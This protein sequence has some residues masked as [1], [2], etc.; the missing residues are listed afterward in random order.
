[1]SA[2]EYHPEFYSRPI[3]LSPEEMNDPWTALRDV[4]I[5]TSLCEMRKVLWKMVEA[6]VGT[7]DPGAF[8]TAEQRQNVLLAYHDMERALEAAWLL[9]RR[10]KADKTSLSTEK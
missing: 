9:Y 5:G 7:A 8:E 1:M 10:R 4:F 2:F 3:R 6:C